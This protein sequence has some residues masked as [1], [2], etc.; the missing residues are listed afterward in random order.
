MLLLKVWS[1]AHVFSDHLRCFQSHSNSLESSKFQQSF[2]ILYFLF[3]W[4][5]LIA[6]VNSG[7][8]K[9]SLHWSLL[10]TSCGRSNFWLIF[11]IIWVMLNTQYFC[12]VKYISMWNSS[13]YSLFLKTSLGAADL[14]SILSSDNK[15]KDVHLYDEHLYCCGVL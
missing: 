14:A 9:I 7:F 15:I 8:K 10:W 6:R 1:C 13:F 4:K 11:L 3:C 2:S 12:T 5:Y